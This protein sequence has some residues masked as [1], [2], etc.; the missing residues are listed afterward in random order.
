MYWDIKKAE[1]Y[2]VYSPLNLDKNNFISALSS[3]DLSS[4]NIIDI[5]KIALTEPVKLALSNC[6]EAH[7]K[8]HK[9]F[10]VVIGN[11]LSMSDLE[12][13]FVVVPSISEAIDYI[14]M[15]ELEKNL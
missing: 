4:N 13:L 15:E 9:S 8:V 12:E 6:N 3:I 1:T 11:M 2:T 10:V 14:Y 5:S 7:L